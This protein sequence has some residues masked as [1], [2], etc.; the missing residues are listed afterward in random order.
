MLQQGRP[1]SLAAPPLLDERSLFTKA[2]TYGDRGD[3]F[4]H[5][6]SSRIGSYYTPTASRACDLLEKVLH[7]WL[8][9]ATCGPCLLMSV[10][11][12]A[13]E[14]YL[15]VFFRTACCVGFKL[16]ISSICHC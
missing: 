13:A 16:K 1:A 11:S 15:H 2:A 3:P 14:S 8:Y 9:M 10:R 6:P 12:L 7:L 5:P 4:Y